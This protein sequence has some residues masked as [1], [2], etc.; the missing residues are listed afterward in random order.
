MLRL[1]LCKMLNSREG[2]LEREK[3]VMKLL[4]MFLEQNLDFIVVGGY[5]IATYKKRFSIDL[6]IV[7]AEKDLKKFES[8]LTKHKYSFDYGK[9]IALIYGEK[10]KRFIRQ[11]KNFPVNADL[12]INGLVSRK[13]DAAWSFDYVKK[14]SNKRKLNGLKFLIPEK[15]LLLAM[16]FHSGKLSDVR[17]I[18]ALMPCD[19]ENL[20]KHV[21]RGDVIKLK[22][23]IKK[24]KEFLEK[25][26]FD[27]GFKGIF[28][29]Q[30]YRE[31]DVEKTKELINNLL[32]IL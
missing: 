14:Y 13:T 9:E 3:E 20:R 7:M 10:F 29:V 21:A 6:D 15:E 27:D 8:L 5:A 25:P 22:E 23:I 16:K 18:M 2:L 26:Q 19:G 32:K 28:G 30:V 11:V 24:Q 12:L 17:D 31:D 4:N 1:V